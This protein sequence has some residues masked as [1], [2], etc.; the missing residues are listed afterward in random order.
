MAVQR[1]ENDND[2]YFRLEV[3]TIVFDGKPLVI[4]S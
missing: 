2:N 4:I 3:Q 1:S